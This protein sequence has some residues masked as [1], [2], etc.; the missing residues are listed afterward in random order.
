MNDT[1]KSSA[2]LSDEKIIK[3]AQTLPDPSGKGVRTWGNGYELDSTGN[4][5]VPAVP[6]D[7]ALDFAHRLLKAA[8]NSPDDAAT[9]KLNWT[10]PQEANYAVSY[11]H[12]KAS[13]AFGDILITWKGWKE[14]PEYFI[15]EHPINDYYCGSTL[16]DAKA[17]AETLFFNALKQEL[18]RE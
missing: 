12:V 10:E 2:C 17:H 6:K 8:L 11:N 9:L 3:I 14:Y 5:R 4:Y 1:V 18:N 13:T 7:L 15:E 16:A